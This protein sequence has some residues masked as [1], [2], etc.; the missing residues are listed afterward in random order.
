MCLERFI[1]R[2]S[3]TY[4]IGKKEVYPEIEY[5]AEFNYMYGECISRK[6]A[7]ELYKCRDKVLKRQAKLGAGE[8]QPGE[9]E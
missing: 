8:T 2:Y 3:E 7:E 5:C 4:P 6:E 1:L 9:D